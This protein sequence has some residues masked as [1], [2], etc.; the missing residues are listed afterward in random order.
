MTFSFSSELGNELMLMN[1][2]KE[3]NILDPT[4]IK[5]IIVTSEDKIIATRLSEITSEIYDPVQLENQTRAVKSLRL[6]LLSG[7]QCVRDFFLCLQ[8]NFLAGQMSFYPFILRLHT[9][10]AALRA[11]VSTSLKQP[12]CMLSCLFLQ[13]TAV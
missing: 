4:V 1:I 10:L 13:T 5:N 9:Q 11:N 8:E 3:G 7:Q 12:N 6:D 2:N